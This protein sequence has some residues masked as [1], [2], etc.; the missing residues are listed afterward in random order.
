MI[1]YQDEC[2]GCP[3]EKGCLGS[4]CQYSNIP[5]F[6]CDECGNETRS[7]YCFADTPSRELCHDCMTRELDNAIDNLTLLEKMEIFNVKEVHQKT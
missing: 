2:V 4:S 1:K 3:P 5:Y 6:Y 7:L